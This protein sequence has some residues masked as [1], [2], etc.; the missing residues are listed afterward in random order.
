MFEFFDRGELRRYAFELLVDV[1]ELR[2]R[3][4]VSVSKNLE[5]ERVNR[6]NECGF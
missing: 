3:G 2:V 1:S 4:G 6:V 5:T